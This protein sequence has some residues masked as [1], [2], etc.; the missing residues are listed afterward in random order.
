MG[1]IVQCDILHPLLR[2]A[3]CQ[4]IRSIFRVAVDR[5]AEDSRCPFLR[6][7]GAPFLILVQKPSQIFPP[8]WAVKRAEHSDLLLCGFFQQALHLYSVF[9]NDV[10]IIPA[11]IVQPI[12]LKLHLIRE[13]V[14]V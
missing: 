4:Q 13:K 5:T 11:G 1:Y 8:N 3:I 10:G 7:I 9:S 12:P 2:Q 14:A 6:R